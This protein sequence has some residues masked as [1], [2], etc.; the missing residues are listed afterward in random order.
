MYTEIV[1]KTI[2]F[3]YV[4]IFEEYFYI[5]ACRDLIYKNIRLVAKFTLKVMMVF[6]RSSK[7]RII[8]VLVRDFRI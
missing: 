7:S 4:F 1:Y 3:M 2:L 5:N 8:G 6:L